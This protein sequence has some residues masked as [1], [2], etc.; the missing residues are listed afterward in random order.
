MVVQGP[1]GGGAWGVIVYWVQSFNLGKSRD[2]GEI[3]QMG[4]GEGA[5]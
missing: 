5:M 2:G 1:R 4:G 3:L